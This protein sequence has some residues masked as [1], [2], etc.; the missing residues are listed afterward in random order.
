VT[1]SKLWTNRSN[2]YKLNSN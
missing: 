1:W 2:N